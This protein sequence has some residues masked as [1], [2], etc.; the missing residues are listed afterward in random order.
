[1]AVLVAGRS[2]KDV[3]PALVEAVERTKTSVPI[4]KKEF[5]SS[6]KSYWVSE[7]ENMAEAKKRKISKRSRGSSQK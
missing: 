5:L 4:W 6:G 2:M 7:R 3:F 1:M